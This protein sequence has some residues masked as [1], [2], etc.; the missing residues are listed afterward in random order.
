MTHWR[1][2]YCKLFL[3][4]DFFFNWFALLF[5]HLLVVTLCFY[6]SI[7]GVFYFFKLAFWK[8]FANTRYAFFCLINV[9]GNDMSCHL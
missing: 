4:G 3:S 2:D 9:Q 5:I 1:T 8:C 7:A 6:F